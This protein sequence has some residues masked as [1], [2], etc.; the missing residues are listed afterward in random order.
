APATWLIVQ[1]LMSDKGLTLDVWVKTVGSRITRRAVTTSLSI[2]ALSAMICTIVGA[3]VAWQISR[4]ATGR[5][6]LWLALLNVAANFGGIGLAFAYLAT[7][8]RVGM[9]TLVLHGL[10]V[11]FSPPRPASFI[12]LSLA[13][14]YVNIPLYI[15]LTIPAMGVVRDEWWEAAQTSAAT[16]GQFWRYVGLPL[17]TPFVAAGWVLIYS[18]ARRW[19]AT[20]LPDGYTV[21]Y[22]ISA[23]QDP[24]LF[25]AFV[26]SVVLA[27]ATVA[28]DVLVVVPATYWAYVRNRRIRIIAEMAAVVP[29]ALPWVAIAFGILLLSGRFAPALLGTPL[30]LMLAYAAVHF[31]FLY[32]AVDGAMAAAD[33]VAL[34]EAAENRE[35]DRPAR[36][37]QVLW[38]GACA[39]WCI[40]GGGSRG[41]GRS[42]GAVGMREDDAAPVRRRSAATRWRT[43]PH[44]RQGCH[45]DADPRAAHRDGLP[46]LRTVPEHDPPQ[47]HRVPTGRAERTGV[48]DH[49]TGE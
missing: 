47:Q 23:L 28:I 13:Y 32:W 1:S 31:P 25:G 5:R 43:D 33:V 46:E 36:C 2:S 6:A 38:L 40:V 20:I 12:G 44:R 17:L 7:L 9:V 29:F 30:L 4:M 24:R 10:G 35:R 19:T 42:A 27:G 15:L 39:R 16:R 45:W 22:W 8:G 41:T 11:A 34:S 3:P 49:P 37:D 48:G 26:R 14:Q 18:L 21:Q